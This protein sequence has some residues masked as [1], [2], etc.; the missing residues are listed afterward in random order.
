MVFLGYEDAAC[1][2]SLSNAVVESEYSCHASWWLLAVLSA[3]GDA[4]C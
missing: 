2:C 3:K 1:V 4:L